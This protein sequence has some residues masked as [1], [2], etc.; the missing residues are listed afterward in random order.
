LQQQQQQP[1]YEQP[2]LHQLYHQHQQQLPQY[3]QQQPQ[4]ALTQQQ[5]QQQQ[6]PQ[7]YMMYGSGSSSSSMPQMI[8]VPVAVPAQADPMTAIPRTSSTGSASSAARASQLHADAPVFTPSAA[9]QAAP[10]PRPP[11]PP[12]PIPAGAVFD[13]GQH[14]VALLALPGSEADDND[15]SNQVMDALFRQ[16]EGYA[17]KLLEPQAAPQLAALSRLQP[18]DLA[19]LLGEPSPEVLLDV[20]WQQYQQRQQQ[21]AQPQQQGASQP[22]AEPTPAEAMR[23]LQQQRVEQQ[24]KPKQQGASGRDGSGPCELPSDAAAAFEQ[25]LPPGMLPR[26]WQ[27]FASWGELEAKVCFTVGGT[28]AEVI[29]QN[30]SKY[31]AAMKAAAAAAAVVQL[32]AAG[33]AV[34]GSSSS[35]SGQAFEKA[36]SSSVGFKV[37][38]RPS[39]YNSIDNRGRS[40]VQ[41]N[42]TARRDSSSSSSKDDV[43][44]P[45]N[46]RLMRLGGP[47]EAAAHRKQFLETLLAAPAAAEYAQWLQAPAQKERL[48]VLSRLAP[49]DLARLLQQRHPEQLLEQVY[50]HSVDTATGSQVGLQQQKQEHQQRQQQQEHQRWQQQQQEYVEEEAYYDAYGD[51]YE[52]DYDDAYEEDTHSQQGQPHVQLSEHQRLQ[53][54]E[55]WRPSNVPEEIAA[56]FAE[57]L[58][59]RLPQDWRTYVSWRK[60]EDACFG[61]S[62]S[63]RTLFR[64]AKQ[65][66]WVT[67]QGLAGQQGGQQQPRSAQP[68]E[69]SSTSAGR[70]GQQFN[71]APN[72]MTQS[73]ASVFSAALLDPLPSNW[74]NYAGWGSLEAMMQS[75]ESRAVFE[76]AKAKAIA[77]VMR[78]LEAGRHPGKTQRFYDEVTGRKKEQQQQEQQQEHAPAAPQQQQQQQHAPAAPQ[79]QQQQQEQQQITRPSSGWRPDINRLGP[80]DL[81]PQHAAE[82]EA[83]VPAGLLPANWRHCYTFKR[84]EE[85]L[86]FSMAAGPARYVLLEKFRAARNKARDDTRAAVQQQQVQG[87]SRPGTA[88]SNRAAPSAAAQQ[89]LQQQQQQPGEQQQLLGKRIYAPNQLSREAA[90]AFVAAMPPGRLPP[91]WRLFARWDTMEARVSFTA[92]DGSVQDNTKHYKLEKQKAQAATAAAAAAAAGG[93]TPAA[94]SS[95][96]HAPQAAGAA[97]FSDA[98]RRAAAPAAK[99]PAPA[100]AADT[101]AGPAPAGPAAAGAAAA[102]KPWEGSSHPLSSSNSG[103]AVVPRS[104]ASSSAGVTR[105]NSGA[106]V[107]SITGRSSSTAAGAGVDGSGR[108]SSSS[109][110]VAGANAGEVTDDRNYIPMGKPVCSKCKCICI[111]RNDC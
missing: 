36:G 110:G 46:V 54:S 1:Q 71:V 42:G 81:L 85:D 43:F 47:A 49:A 94:G 82:F 52:E 84:L 70:A 78:V 105:V 57:E 100:A 55:M 74:R 3:E 39:S 59:K 89:E 68:A 30:M 28:G 103:A 31:K 101:A 95:S 72:M 56:A 64:Q 79:Q 104:S 21:Q 12:A 10:L 13:L 107:V 99:P 45:C 11:P 15:R 6:Q 26:E 33:V 25:A 77:A 90:E 7:P 102:A 88:G 51:E 23:L 62:Q 106:P 38:P 97:L 83:A 69:S 37:V 17:M 32:E 48:S 9:A 111:Q 76:Q 35:S 91:D 98:V 75:D 5:Q 80:C 58:G 14:Q 18:A 108:R 86:D 63:H 92:G 40:A 93:S 44:R 96:M 109:S 50:K 2:Q 61:S 73:I 67:L 65:R 53:L 20:F 27:Q 66:A 24:Q 41:A 8:S 22:A 29:R 34:R 60:L 87:G 4:Q 16:A 19:V